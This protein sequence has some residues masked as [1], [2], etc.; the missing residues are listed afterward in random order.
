MEVSAEQKKD[1]R[2]IDMVSLSAAIRA[3]RG[4]R[5]L[6]E[7]APEIGI[8]YGQLCDFE[9]RARIPGFDNYM[10]LCGWLEVE[11]DFFVTTEPTGA[12]A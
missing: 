8:S 5:T 7:V 6:R 10:Q 2:R 11:M 12:T 1:R 9:R 4:K 3:K